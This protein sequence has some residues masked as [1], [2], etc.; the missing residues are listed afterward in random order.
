V[1]NKLYTAEML[2]KSG[3]SFDENIKYGMDVL[4][5]TSIVLAENCKGVYIDKSVYHYLQ[6][7]AAITKSTSYAIKYD[8]LAVYKRVEELLIENGYAEDAFWARGFNCHHASVI[9]E[10]AI[11]N[12][13]MD[14]LLAMRKIINDYCD[15]Y[16]ATNQ[17]YPEKFERMNR[18]RNG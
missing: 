10:L 16:I 9:A 1:W 14:V 7:A 13:D 17:K 15:D 6:R 12:N 11:Q 3:L 8:I 2:K 5:Y 4:F 18:L